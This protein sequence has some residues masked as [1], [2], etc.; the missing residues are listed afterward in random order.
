MSTSELPSLSPLE[1]LDDSTL[2]RLRDHLKKI[3]FG[4]TELESIVRA[5]G[6]VHP[7]VRRPV[8]HY[9][10]RQVK[11]PL[12]PVSRALMFGDP[13]SAAEL[14]A[15]FGDLSAPLRESGL[16]C[17]R[18][19]GFVSP[20]CVTVIDELFVVS[21]DLSQGGDAVMGHAP[22]TIALTTAAF[23]SQR[24]GRALDLGCGAGAVALV[25]SKRTRAVIATDINKRALSLAR[26]NC[27]LNGVVNIDVREGSLF[28]P[29]AKE[30]FDL[31]ASQPPFVPQAET[32]KTGQFMAGGERG[33][34]LP[35]AVL[36]TAPD[37][38]VPG[39][40]A[41]L[42]IE[43]G[44]GKKEKPPGAR[45]L[46]TLAGAPVDLLV[47][48]LPAGT[49]DAHAVEYA[50]GLH[51]DLGSAFELEAQGRRA[52]LAKMGFESMVPTLTVMRRVDDRKPRA[53][54]WSTASFSQSPPSVKR[55]DALLHARE[56]TVSMDRVM[57]AKVR[58]VEGTRLREEQAGI[59]E[60]TELHALL[61]PE[62][63]TNPL[64]ITP[65]LLQLAHA[66]SENESVRAAINMYLLQYA[67]DARGDQVAVMVAKGLL[68]GLFE[69]VDEPKV[70]V[71]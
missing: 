68:S 57:A 63:M 39:G 56:V 34:A 70:L 19:G 51:P 52:H 43:W 12:G 64:P 61:P 47:F 29:V 45:I 58:L 25:L 3:G 59:G 21:D 4:P 11:G 26:F 2:T 60:K 54:V 23:P 27:R 42:F 20:F 30:R 35:L 28:E 1:A 7:L 38:L 16:L 71:T 46:V 32:G 8:L 65:E 17:E 62:A 50:A 48:Q 31:I 22:S 44:H 36:E 41:V 33:D 13:I 66:L 18:A 14:E 55:L 5:A 40:R 15:A 9:H 67:P 69:V 49:A 37:H 53:D 6:A 24:I 10:A